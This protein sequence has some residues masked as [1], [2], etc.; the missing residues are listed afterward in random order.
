MT[1][2]K[3]VAG[4][5]GLVLVLIFSTGGMFFAFTGAMV[6]L[7]EEPAAAIPPELET[8]YRQVAY[9]T[10]VPWTALAAWDAAENG[11]AIPVRSLE[12]IL[13]A[14]IQ[15]LLIEKQRQAEE[16]CRR[17]DDDPRYCPPAPPELTL[18]EEMT[19]WRQSHAEWRGLVIRHIEEHAAALLPVL[20]EFLRNPEV[21]YRRFLRVAAAARAAELFEG[22][23]LLESL[24]ADEDEIL[25]DPIPPPADW[26]PIDGFAWPVLAPITSR[27]GL[28]V[29]PI[30]GVQRLHAGIDLGVDSGTQIRASKAGTVAVAE[31][32]PTYGLLVI[33]D[34]GGGYRSLYAHHSALA[35]SAGQQVEQ[36]QVVGLAGSTGWSTGPH[37]HFE[38]HYEGAPVDP[39]LLLTQ[40]YGRG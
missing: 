5:V 24:S 20:A 19:L 27:F 17:N 9:R 13:A 15:E 18:Q 4:V 30:D 12:E 7:A 22:Y 8:A 35:V 23:Q 21:V 29:S 38:I 10:G 6:M 37:L 16:W 14:K 11:F 36:G 32:N 25:I 40:R 1:P 31:M 26:V 2:E 28:R 34:H 39:L 3:V 33:I